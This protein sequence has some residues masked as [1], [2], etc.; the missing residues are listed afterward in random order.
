MAKILTPTMRIEKARRLIQ[1]AREIPVPVNV[2]WDFLSYTAQ[3]KDKLKQAFELLKLMK[4]T[5]S[6]SQAEKEEATAVIQEAADAEKEILA[7]AKEK[8]NATATPGNSL[9]PR[10]QDAP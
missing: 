6:A 1:E 2:G 5:V 7:L 4:H 8:L 10:D 9:S 3:V